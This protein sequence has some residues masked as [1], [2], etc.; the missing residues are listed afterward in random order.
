MALITKIQ[1]HSGIAVTV[2][3]IAIALFIVGGDLLSSNSLLRGSGGTSIGQIAGTDIDAKKYQAELDQLEYEYQLANNKQPGEQERQGIRDQ[4]WTTLLNKYGFGPEYDK[5][6]LQVTADELVDMVQGENIHPGLK[7]AF[8]D[9]ATG[10]VDRDKIREYLKQINSLKEKNEQAAQQYAIWMNFERKLPEDR[11]R[12]K[13]EALLTKSIYVTS[14]EAERE[15]TA[16]TAKVSAKYVFVPYFSIADSTIKPT[17]E[18][19]SA[20]LADHKDKYKAQDS[21]TIDYVQFMLTPDREDSAAF[22]TEVAGLRSEFANAPDD[23]AYAASK[24]DSPEKLK[25]IPAN[26]LPAQIAGL[27]LQK[28][29]VYGPFTLGDNVTL[30]KV[31]DIKN[32]GDYSAKA[33]HI[34]IKWNSTADTSKAFAKAKAQGVLSKIKGGAS[35]EEM[36]RIYGTDGTS[37]QGGDLGWFSAGRMVKPFQDA[38]FAASGRGLLP[39]LT[40]TEFGYHIIKVTE[41]KTNL[42]YQVVTLARKLEA[43]SRTRE[44]VYNKARVFMTEATDT[45]AFYA[46]IKKA[47]LTK[48]SAVNLQKNAQYVNDIADARS[49]VRWAFLE[50]KV[51]E[52]AKSPFDFKDR[53]VVVALTRQSEEGKPTVAEFRDQLAAEVRKQVKAEQIIAKINGAKT[54]EEMKAKYGDAAILNSAPDITLASTSMPDVGYDPIAVGRLFGLKQGASTAPFAA[55]TGVVALMSEKSTPAPKIADYTSYKTSIQQR[56]AGPVTYYLTEAVKELKGVKDDRIQ[57]Q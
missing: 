52:L 25:S 35:F 43:S 23:T 45:A 10:Q 32:E 56:R 26:E 21:R 48:Q 15:Y 2:I 5:I 40:E 46:A 12:T 34:L 14:A 39:T 4:A 13:Y 31:R 1:Q 16:Q 50:G 47:N 37:T 30:Y 33:S 6:G 19:L 8:T 27:K 57:I 7:Q 29:S 51:G 36:A 24:S 18:Q 17:E 20:Y 41:P 3:V 11:K 42:K 22:N 53:Y 9:P 55:E 44:L 54:L 49:I 38:V 28:D